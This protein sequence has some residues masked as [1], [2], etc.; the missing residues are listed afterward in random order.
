M[1]I[2]IIGVP[3]NGDGTPPEVENPPQS[4]RDEGVISLLQNKGHHLT[5]FGDLHIPMFSNKKDPI[6][7]VLN[8]DAW[9]EVSLSLSRTLGDELAQDSFPIVLGGDCAILMGIVDAFN[10]M[11][12]PLN[13]FFLDG[14]ADFHTLDTSTTGEPADLELAALTGHLSKEIV[15]MTGRGPLLHEENVIAYGIGELDSIERS[16][17]MLV[18]R[19][20]ILKDGIESTFRRSLGS[21][22]NP[23]LPLWLHF[24]VDVLDKEI[25]PAIQYP[26]EGGLSYNEIQELLT[27]IKERNQLIGM[28]ITC[29]HP[30]LDYDKKGIKTLLLLFKEI[31]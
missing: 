28:S 9:R 15:Y 29:Y 26:V 13:L 24:D 18:D 12:Q 11:N 22:Q 10:I 23:D 1:K 16:N 30:K 31:F 25:M 4:L 27:L 21:F 5:D 19:K 6:T 14:H 17:I 7:N 3:F 8:F 20:S 2:T